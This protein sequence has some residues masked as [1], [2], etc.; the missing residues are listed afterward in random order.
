MSTINTM[1]YDSLREAI[2]VEPIML[3]NGEPVYTFESANKLAMAEGVNAK[4]GFKEE[5]L[6]IREMNPSQ[7]TYKRTNKKYPAIDPKALFGNRYKKESNKAGGK[8]TDIYT[9]VTDYRA[10]QEQSTGRIYCENVLA[11]QIKVTKDD[12][13]KAKAELIK[14][15]QVSS[16][17]F[18]NE[19]T[20]ELSEKDMRVILPLI[21]MSV[22]Q[23]NITTDEIGL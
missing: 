15:I 7:E 20:R 17:T 13:G 10:L 8:P 9:I 16:D 5:S 22:N 6:A 23:N 1:L 11:H 21:G 4:L 19:F 3:V 12:N 18:I 14:T 2:E